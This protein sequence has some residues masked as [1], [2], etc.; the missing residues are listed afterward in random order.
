MALHGTSKAYIVDRLKREG[1]TALLDAVTTGKI[2]AMT[3]AV[4]L[5]WV[6]RP[7]KRGGN[8]QRTKRIAHQ[9]RTITGEGLS[10]GQMME[11]WLGP[12]PTGSL[13]DSREQLV[14]AWE[15]NRDAIMRQWGSRGRRPA[16]WYEF[17][18]EGPRPP[19]DEERSTL[20]RAGVLAESERAELER[21]WR[22]EVETAQAPDFTVN[23]GSGE[24]LKGDC[25]RAAHYAH[26]DIP[27]ELTRKWLA[28]ARRRRTRAI[29]KEDDAVR[30]PQP[31]GPSG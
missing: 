15:A 13:F 24:L 4:E 29:R 16:G 31:V 20:W 17:E 5:G 11:L 30:I 14:A 10:G 19:Y 22:A 21:E 27:R 2:T 9:V 6:L 23:D 25:A 8:T 1:E 18:H 7:P 28:A 3:A 12:N 26:H